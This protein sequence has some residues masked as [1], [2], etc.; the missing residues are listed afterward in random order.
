MKENYLTQ[1]IKLDMK[2]AG[3]WTWKIK[4]S[5]NDGIPDLLCINDGS[6]IFIE[7]KTEDGELS[8]IQK[9]IRGV[10]IKHGA[11]VFVV[12]GWQDF[13]SQKKFFK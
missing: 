10:L 5:A 9:Y 2:R 13:L 4:T 12:Y 11:K 6:Y 8:E 3:W 1:K 7:V